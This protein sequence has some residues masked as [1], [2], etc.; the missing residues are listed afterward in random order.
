M[1]PPKKI[2]KTNS[3]K[4]RSQPRGVAICQYGRRYRSLA[5]CIASSSH[6]C[7]AASRKAVSSGL[8]PLSVARASISLNNR[9]RFSIALCGRRALRRAIRRFEKSDKAYTKKENQKYATAPSAI[10]TMNILCSGPNSIS[11]PVI[12][13]GTNPVFSMMSPST[14]D[15]SKPVRTRRV[16]GASGSSS[17][18]SA[19][20]GVSIGYFCNLDRMAFVR[21]EAARLRG[22]VGCAMGAQSHRFGT[23][24]QTH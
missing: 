1:Y 23:V 8:A 17:R 2:G 3:S 21:W 10:S 14:E 6:A 12:L 5:V 19:D 9:F 11:S 4:S 24:A 16:V 13:F 15:A 18:T 22:N 7:A 20:V